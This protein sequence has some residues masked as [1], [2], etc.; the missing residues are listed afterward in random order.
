MQTNINNGIKIFFGLNFFK[1]I[2]VVIFTIILLFNLLFFVGYCK[3]NITTSSTE[4]SCG[5]IGT[6]IAAVSFLYVAFIGFL[7]VDIHQGNAPLAYFLGAITHIILSYFLACL[8]YLIYS[9]L[10]G[11]KRNKN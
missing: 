7:T 11:K 8:V 6:V 9:K 1:I 5:K 3:Y 4:Y 2:F 10:Q